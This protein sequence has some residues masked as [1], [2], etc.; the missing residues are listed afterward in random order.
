MRTFLYRIAIRLK[1]YGERKGF[2]S[3][4]RLGT[5]LKGWVIR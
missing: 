4:V 3:L 2:V 5:F 1:E